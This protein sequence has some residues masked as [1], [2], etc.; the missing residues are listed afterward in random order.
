ME[1]PSKV[2]EYVPPMARKIKEFTS[3]H[4]RPATA[5]NRANKM[6]TQRAID[7]MARYLNGSWQADQLSDDWECK[8]TSARLHSDGSLTI[9]LFENPILRLYKEKGIVCRVSVFDGGCYDHQGNP[10]HL[11]RERL[12][13]LLDAL[14]AMKYLPDNVK[15]IYDNEY[16][17]CYLARFEQK[18]ALNGKYHKQID[19]QCNPI[20]FVIERIHQ[21]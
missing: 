13:G 6:V 21:A 17:I 2:K 8:G 10:S 1:M 16:E 11:T 20:E 15:V 9:S 14:S 4:A 5:G 7:A 12:N 18:A 3:S 19:V